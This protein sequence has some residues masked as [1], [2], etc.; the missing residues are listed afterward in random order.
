VPA[1]VKSG[2]VLKLR[3]ACQATDGYPGDI[4]IKI[5]IK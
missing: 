5:K 3:G 4:L 1:G 2:N